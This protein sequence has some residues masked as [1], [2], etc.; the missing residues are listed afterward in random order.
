MAAF[1]VFE[2]G[3]G[4]GKSTQ[5]VA[6]FQRLRRRGI[7]ARRV[8][9]PGGTPLGESLRRI[10]K[11]HRDLTPATEL[12]LFSAARAH[13]VRQA[14][15]PALSGGVIVLC[16]RFTASTVAYQGY[17]RGLDLEL[18]RRLN[19]A[20]T[21]GLEPDL[22]IL[23]DLPVEAALARRAKASDGF[24]AAPLEFHRRVRQG[25]L[26]QAAQA[27]GRWLVLDGAQP[28]AALARQVW[29]KVQPLL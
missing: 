9:E 26:Q 28:K 25:Y 3:D 2:G 24:E 16:D 11:S 10:L 23:L 12:F 22:T 27:P 5:A 4:A 20:A 6:L 21:D 17:G 14:I 1:I 8:R 15:R 13:L 19:L 7:P 18:V 29:E